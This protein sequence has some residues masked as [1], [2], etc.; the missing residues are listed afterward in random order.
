M[1]YFVQAGEIKIKTRFSGNSLFFY[2]FFG[3]FL[4]IFA[5]LASGLYRKTIIIELLDSRLIKK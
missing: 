1:E 2:L 5:F 3:L 4:Q